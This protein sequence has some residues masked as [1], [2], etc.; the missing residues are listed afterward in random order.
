MKRLLFC[1]V[2]LA[3]SAGFSPSAMAKSDVNISISAPPPIVFVQPPEL[4]VLPGTYVYAAP[5]ITADIFF[6]GGWWWRPWEGRWYRSRDYRSGWTHHKS[7]PTFYA[8]IPSNW[9]NYYSERRWEGNDWNYQRLPCQLVQSKWKGWE[10][11]NHW[12]KQGTWGVQGLQPHR[13]RHQLKA[14]GPAPTQQFLE[15]TAR[16]RKAVKPQNLRQEEQSF[17]EG[18]GQGHGKN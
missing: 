14:A 6:Y 15:K 2:L 13:Y 7:V 17:H 16:F 4:I 3:L 8:A 9:R 18:K 12:E 1:I 5:D 11:N 10:L